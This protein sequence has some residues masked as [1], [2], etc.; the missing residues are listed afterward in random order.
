M[1]KFWTLSEF[2]AYFSLQIWLVVLTWEDMELL[3]PSVKNAITKTLLL[4][5]ISALSIFEKIVK[6]TIVK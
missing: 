3:A 1:F 6:K 2:C 5:A 4:F